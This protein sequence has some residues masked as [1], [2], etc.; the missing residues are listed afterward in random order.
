MIEMLQ[1]EQLVAFAE[2]GTLSKAAEE[3]H[4]SQPTL[5]RSM[6]KIEEDFRVPLFEHKKNKLDLNESGWLAVDYAKKVLHDCHDMLERVRAFDRAA[7]TILIGS[8]APAPLWNLLPMLSNLYPDLTIGSEMKDNELLITGLQEDFYQI[9]ILPEQINVP[10]WEIIP[11]GEEHLCFSLPK[12]HRLAGEKGLYLKDLDG[13]NMLLLS[14]IGFWHEL[15]EK[16]MPHSKFLMQNERFD[17][18]ELVSSSIL[19]SFVT[20]A[21]LAHLYP[22]SNIYAGRVSIPIL[23]EEA[24]VHYYCYFQKKNG[25]K[26]KEFVREMKRYS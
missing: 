10:G 22:S 1:L 25:Q 4:I 26:M 18:D 3:L 20:D 11:C 6:K 15:H 16:K 12:S 24:N 9:I 2:Y 13:E 5:T 8:C 17:F 14:D 23:D 21:A 7:H 19:P